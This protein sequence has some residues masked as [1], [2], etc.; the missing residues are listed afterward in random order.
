MTPPH[1]LEADDDDEIQIVD[2][3]SKILHE[4]SIIDLSRRK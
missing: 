2:P 4:Q 1:E 3:S